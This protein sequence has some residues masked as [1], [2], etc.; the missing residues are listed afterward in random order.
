MIFWNTTQPIRVAYIVWGFII[1]TMV[2][3]VPAIFIPLWGDDYFFLQQAKHARLNNLSWMLPFY[4]ESETGFWRPLSMDVPWRI[5]E[6]YL[7]GNSIVAHAFSLLLWF[8]S[9]IFVYLLALKISN[10]LNWNNS[11]T[12]SLVA[13]ALYSFSAVHYL[14]LHWVSAINSSILVI[15][16]CLP[17]IFWVSIINGKSS[18]FILYLLMPFLQILALF[19]KESAILLPALMLC[20]SLFTNKKLNSEQLLTCGVCIIT[21]VIWF[22]FFNQ[23][24]HHRDNSYE[25]KFG[26]NII[27][28]SVALVAWMLNIPREAIRLILIGQVITALVWLTPIVILMITF[29]YFVF[30]GA[31]KF[32]SKFQL[33]AILGFIFFGYA[34]YFLLSHQSYEYYAAIAIILPIIGVARSLT[35]ANRTYIGLLVFAIAS[36]VSIQ[37]SR[38]LDYPGLI[39]RAYW[40]ETQL[41]SLQ[42]RQITT[43]LVICINNEH[44]F[45]AIG[46]KGLA[47]RLGID[48]DQI[49]LSERCDASLGQITF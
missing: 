21:C 29:L 26:V 16:I 10:T 11:K 43:P 5:I 47:W 18:K 34:P 41:A 4:S 24:T 36:F 19:C 48:E 32:L 15:F 27:Q 3:W 49:V 14:V 45:Y 35:I 31:R 39:G 37:G 20:I 17:L 28:N 13:A 33:L 40:A 1:F 9:V 23:L 22:Y 44:Q 42:S 46:I 8:I 7:H 6:T 38:M 25:I 12:I 30:D 2:T